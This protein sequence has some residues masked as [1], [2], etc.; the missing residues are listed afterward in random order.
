MRIWLRARVG[1]EV[2]ASIPVVEDTV[3]GWGWC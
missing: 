2:E 3:E 1:V